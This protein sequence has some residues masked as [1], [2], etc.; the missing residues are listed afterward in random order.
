MKLRME[1][2]TH[3]VTITRGEE[4]AVF[5]I[6]PLNPSEGSRLIKK[7]TPK[8][9]WI[10]NTMEEKEIDFVELQIDRIDKTI[11]DWDITDEKGKK[12]ACTS[13]NKKNAYLNNPEI[14][15][16]VMDK[17]SEI[18]KGISDA[19]EVAEKN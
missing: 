8:K 18:A 1:K 16:E 13:E 17:A 15:N 3:K 6:S 5:E 14:I 7:H 9:R 11:I 2:T 4:T 19:E 12:V 10:G